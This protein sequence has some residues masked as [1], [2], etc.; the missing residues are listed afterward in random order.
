MVAHR[1]SVKATVIPNICSI[2]NILEFWC[3]L[4]GKMD[5]YI[6]WCL[7]GIIWILV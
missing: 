1:D 5:I 2:L 7:R 6:C 4:V 3:F